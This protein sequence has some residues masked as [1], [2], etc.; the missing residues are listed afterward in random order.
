MQ[1]NAVRQETE[2][3]VQGVAVSGS[4]CIWFRVQPDSVCFAFNATTLI[5]CFVFLSSDGT[6]PGVCSDQCH[7][8]HLLLSYGLPRPRG[9][10]Q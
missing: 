10:P 2:A 3:G 5:V 6:H 9:T 4:I 1:R 8:G 7:P